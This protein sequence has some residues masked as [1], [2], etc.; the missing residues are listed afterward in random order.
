MPRDGARFTW[1]AAAGRI[2]HYFHM[3]E[4]MAVL[5][6]RL[7]DAEKEGFKRAAQLAGMTTSGWTRQTLKRIAASELQAADLNVPFEAAGS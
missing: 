3:I 7:T 1:L 5:Q 6:V 4:R 2:V